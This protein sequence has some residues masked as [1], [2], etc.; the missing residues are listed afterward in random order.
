MEPVVAVLGMIGLG[1]PAAEDESRGSGCMASCARIG[2]LIVVLG[3]TSVAGF[4]VDSNLEES[5]NVGAGFAPSMDL[6]KTG[7]DAVV[8]V[9]ELMTDKTIPKQARRLYGRALKSERK[10]HQEQARQQM[11]AAIEIAPNF[12]QAHAALAIAC[13]NAGAIDEAEN[14]VDI[15]LKL[16]PHYLP[17]H[18]IKGLTQLS[19]GKFREAADTLGKLVKSAPNRKAGHYFLGQALLKLG[20]EE[21][22]NQHL[23]RADE[24][25]RHPHKAQHLGWSR[26]LETWLTGAAPSRW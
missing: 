23:E 22:A 11:Q 19:R 3:G 20:D 9:A 14:H 6:T 12:F 4:A 2:L 25:L 1:L 7:A 18:E 21:T 15:A 13:L 24:L 17:G 5:M 10:G 26:V 16:N 8:S